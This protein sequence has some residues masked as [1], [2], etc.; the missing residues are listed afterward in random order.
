MIAAARRCNCGITFGCT[1]NPSG[2]VMWA[3]EI[4]FSVSMLTAVLF[5]DERL[6]G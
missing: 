1:L 2:N 3:S 4:F 6:L 5:F